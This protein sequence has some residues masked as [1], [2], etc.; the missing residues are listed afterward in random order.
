MINNII[1]TTKISE[2]IDKLLSSIDGFSER[3]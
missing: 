1:Y 2:S 3:E